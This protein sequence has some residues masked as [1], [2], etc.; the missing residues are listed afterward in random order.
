MVAATPGDDKTHTPVT[1]PSPPR[2]N[3]SL[4]LLLLSDK[5][6][7]S[8]KGALTHLCNK[9]GVRGL[10]SGYSGWDICESMLRVRMVVSR[11]RPRMKTQK[12][13]R[14]IWSAGRE[15]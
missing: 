14:A 10:W 13:G 6:I 8:V 3:D 5:T 7:G 2:K 12:H 1:Q 9:G 11:E 4:I 15:K